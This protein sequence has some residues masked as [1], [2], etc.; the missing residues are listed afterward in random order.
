M[1]SNFDI[2]FKKIEICSSRFIGL[3]LAD[4][5]LEQKKLFLT[6]QT[7]SFL[8]NRPSIKKMILKEKESIVKYFLKE[9]QTI[10]ND[11]RDSKLPINVSNFNLIFD[12]SLRL[13][14]VC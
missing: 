3:T 10:R 6:I 1:V 2:Q 11:R 14:K 7:Y 5:A 13:Q 9:I 8:M 4:N 12:T